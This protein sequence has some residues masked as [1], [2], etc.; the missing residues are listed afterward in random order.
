MVG[1]NDRVVG[2]FSHHREFTGFGF[3]FDELS[4]ANLE[5]IVQHSQIFIRHSMHLRHMKKI[6]R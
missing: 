3:P 1:K 6:L 2:A 4:L 5:A